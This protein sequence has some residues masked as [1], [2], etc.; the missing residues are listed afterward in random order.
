MYCLR[1]SVPDGKRKSYTFNVLPVII[2]RA[3]KQAQIVIDHPSISATHATLYPKN[4]TILLKDLGSSTGT[5]KDEQQLSSPVEVSIGETFYLGDILCKLVQPRKKKVAAAAPPPLPGEQLVEADQ[6]YYRDGDQLKGP[7]PSDEIRSQAAKGLITPGTTVMKDGQEVKARDIA[8]LEF[9]TEAAPSVLADRWYYRDGDHLEGPL[10]SDDIRSQAAA[11]V[12][13]PDTTVMKDGQE[14]KA[15][16][17]EGLEFAKELPVAL[18]VGHLTSTTSAE[19]AAFAQVAQSSGGDLLCPHCWHRFSAE[20]SLYIAQHAK[21]TGDPVL[22][23][24]HQQRFLPSRFTATGIAVDAGG[25]ECPDRA[26]PRCHLEIPDAAL[27]PD[28]IILS[29]VGAPSSGKSYLLTSMVWSLRRALAEFALGFTDSDAKTNTTLHDYENLLFNCPEP[30][31]ISTLKKTQLE[32]AEL[33]NTV[34]LQGVRTTLPKP[35]FFN[36]DLLP[37]HPRAESGRVNDS[38]TMV[39]YDNAGESFEA[40]RDTVE[41]PA[42]RHLGRASAIFFL[43]DPTRDGR[44][45]EQ[46][47][48]SPDP[49]VHEKRLLYRQEVLLNEMITRFRRHSGQGRNQRYRKPLIIILPKSDIWGHLIPAES[50]ERPWTSRGFVKELDVD[51]IYSTSLAVRSL[52]LELCPEIVHAAENFARK[53]IFVPA[54]ATGCNAE[55]IDDLFGVRPCNVKSLWVEIPVLLLLEEHGL[56]KANKH[57]GREDCEQ[58]DALPMGDLHG[59]E[60]SDGT[61]HLLP[62]CYLGKYLQCPTSGMRFVANAPAGTTISEDEPSHDRRSMNDQLDSLIDGL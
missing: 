10:S 15:K 38:K 13:T 61:Q 26:C 31:E 14:V 35:F 7:L 44:F 48:D 56:V 2:G 40:G 55:K 60:L 18:P 46:L 47:T 28:P 27:Q 52:F 53:V 8:G 45:R 25:Q 17:I 34:M 30:E 6:W 58:V 1:V 23:P 57:N 4:G 49:Q 36:L 20:D 22:G 51:T 50:P 62:P 9:A 21:L 11:G 37:H 12:I 33:Y 16:D 59:I 24:E 42:T 39:L 32:G 29:V 3:G 5:F 19:P 41:S 43:F 54:S